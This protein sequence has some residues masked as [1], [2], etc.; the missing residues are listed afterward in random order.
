MQWTLPS[1][2]EIADRT[3]LPDDA[4]RMYLEDVELELL[5]YMHTLASTTGGTTNTELGEWTSANRDIERTLQA[6][7]CKACPSS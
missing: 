4:H 1:P 5:A 3:N 7:G 2:P 6:Q